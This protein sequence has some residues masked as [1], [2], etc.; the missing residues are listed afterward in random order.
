[1]NKLII[2]QHLLDFYK[3]KNIHA[4]DLLVKRSGCSGYAFEIVLHNENYS[5]EDFIQENHNGLLVFY[6]KEHINYVNNL[7]ISFN[8]DK[9]NKKVIFNSPH[10]QGVCGCGESFNF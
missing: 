7:F 4:I 3:N 2:A 1:M 5:G 10:A 9:L 8:D 6:K